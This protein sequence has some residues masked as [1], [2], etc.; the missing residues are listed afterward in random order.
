MQAVTLSILCCYKTVQKEQSQRP[1]HC[2]HDGLVP[3]AEYQDAD[4]I[5][6]PESTPYDLLFPSITM[7]QISEIF[8]AYPGGYTG[9]NYRTREV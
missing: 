7:P 5:H 6:V 1:S 3:A 4:M 9:T 8:S 2:K